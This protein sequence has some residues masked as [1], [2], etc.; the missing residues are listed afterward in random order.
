[1]DQELKGK[2][3]LVTGSGRGLGSVMARK[4]AEQGADVLHGRGLWPWFQLGWV[5]SYR[6]ANDLREDPFL[7]NT[8]SLG[9]F[10][11]SWF[12]R[13]HRVSLGGETAVLVDTPA[14]LIESPRFGLALL[15]RYDWTGSR[16]LRDLPPRVT[17]FRDRLEEDSGAV[18]RAPPATEPRWDDD[19]E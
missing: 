11:W 4:L 17:P 3:A 12:A 8:F 9:V 2:V 14:T 1:M 5:G 10:M 15:L 13:G 16:G 18:H 6:P 7:R 19:E